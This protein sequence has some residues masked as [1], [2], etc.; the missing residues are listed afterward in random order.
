M[1]ATLGWDL[2]GDLEGVNSQSEVALNEVLTGFLFEMV[3]TT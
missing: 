1:C 3:G 2:P